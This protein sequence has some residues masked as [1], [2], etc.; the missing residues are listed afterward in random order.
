[1]AAARPRQL[2]EKTRPSCQS[3]Q[4]GYINAMD[5]PLIST[6]QAAKI[7]G[8]GTTTIKR[9][10]DEGKLISLRTAGG[11]RRFR[12]LAVE[13]LVAEPNDALAPMDPTIEDWIHHLTTDVEH[14]RLLAM[15]YETR[16]AHGSWFAVAD[17]VGEVITAIGDYWASGKLSVIE[18]HIATEQLHR[19]LTTCLSQ[20][21]VAQSAPKML[22]ATA[23]DDQHT[24]G[25]LLAE[26]CA[27]E[28]GWRCEWIGAHTPPEMLEQ[29]LLNNPVQLVALSA[30]SWSKDETAL[31][32][33]YQATSVICQKHG[34]TLLLGGLGAWPDQPENAVR[35]YTFAEFKNFFDSAVFD[36]PMTSAE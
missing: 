23:K 13:S 5:N 22:L 17:R 27:R 29:W 12:R 8:V 35:V 25:L 26:L 24:L 32:R 20:Q 21:P 2:P 1:M 6:R 34:M 14:H 19:A 33:Q 4:N 9:W 28:V 10:A 31:F 18:E 3:D 11:H 7:L 15:L 16:A 30:S 36:Q